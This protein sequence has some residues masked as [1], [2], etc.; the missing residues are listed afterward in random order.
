MNFKKNFK[1]KREFLAIVI[2]FILATFAFAGDPAISNVVMV[3]SAPDFGDTVKVDFDVCIAAYSNNAKVA[4]AISSF[5]NFVTA[6]MTGQTFVVYT[7]VVG[8]PSTT[9]LQVGNDFGATLPV[10]PQWADPK[11]CSSCG[12]GAADGWSRHMSYTFKIPDAGWFPGCGITKLYLQIGTDANTLNSDGWVNAVAGCGK[13]SLAWTIGIP[14]KS[15]SIHKRVEGV[16]ADDGDLAVYFIDY[17]YANGQLIINDPLPAGN[18]LQIVSMGPSTIISGAAVGATF[19]TIKWTLP[20]KTG[21][22]GSTTGSVWFLVKLK[23]PPAT[24][25]QVITNTVTGSMTGLADKTSQASLT[26][27][28]ITMNVVKSTAAKTAK[29]GDTITYFIDYEVRGSKLKVFQPFDNMITGALYTGAN[30]PPQWKF[31]TDR[32]VSGIWT[33]MDPCGT[34][35]R[36]IKADPQTVQYYPAILVDTG[37]TTKDRFCTGEIVVDTKI[38]GAYSG[39]DSQIIIRHNGLSGALSN[40]V[41]LIMSVDASPGYIAFQTVTN[42]VWAPIGPPGALQAANT[43]GIVGDKWFSIRINV[44]Q[45]GNDYVYKARAWTKGDPEPGGPTGQNWMITWT[46]AGAATS[47][48]WRCD[49]TGTYTDWRPGLGEQGGDVSTYDSFDNFVVYTPFTSGNTIV[50]DTIPTEVTFTNASTA[51]SGTNGVVKYWNLGNVS[52]TSSSLTWWGVVNSCGSGIVSNIAAMDGD[53]PVIPVISNEVFVTLLCSTPTNTPTST[54]TATFTATATNTPTK[55]STYTFTASPTKTSTP[56]NT[57]T[58]TQSFT[59]TNTNTSTATPTSTSTS[60]NTATPTQSFTFTNTN[61]STA[62]PTFSSTFTFSSTSTSTATPT[63]SFTFTSSFTHTATPTSTATPTNSSTYTVTST[64]T[65]TFTSS[66]TPTITPTSPPFPYLLKIAI[67]NEAGE[68]VRFIGSSPTNNTINQIILSTGGQSNVTLM[69]TQ[70]PLSIYL[71]NVETPN[72]LGDG[73]TNFEWNSNNNANQTTGSGVYYIKFEEL[74]MYGH[75]NV[76]IKEITVMV[77]QEYVEVCI[78]N[79]AGEKIKTIRDYKDVTNTKISLKVGKDDNGQV[80]VVKGNNDINITYGTNLNEYVIWDGLNDQ[81]TAVGAGSY[82]V[83]VSVVS[84]QG[85]TV[86]AAKSIVVLSEKVTYMKDVSIIPNPYSRNILDLK[87][88]KFAWVA[89]TETG[90]M[91]VTVYN[92]AGEKVRTINAT[93]ESGSVLWDVKS[94]ENSRIAA[95]YYVAVFESKS[96]TGHLDRKTA[97]LAIIGSNK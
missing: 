56:T 72:N 19:G 9:P 40:S 20:D 44:T 3:P 14:P 16:L 93:L 63:Q 28:S 32:G 61:T 27:G 57:A 43:P 2:L 88:I 83:Q 54:S 51:V 49:G 70:N 95:G 7:N 48:L 81:G 92:M 31:I 18:V 68:L 64:F 10:G 71:P 66:A 82:E 59:S 5:P 8:V 53:D 78:F 11:T 84:T 13:S 37:D 77:V 87:P 21:Q 41:G 34:G 74:D 69:T 26:V 89:G 42:G 29:I 79:S 1:G 62:T 52:D 33:I 39:A 45:V 25:G 96:T 38:E 6:N 36:Y 80:Y 15:F 85:R 65:V 47:P 46:Q 23:K 90:W 97:K 76:L 60:T 4:I 17:T 94:G 35:D 75:T 55:T 12:S 22:P 73:G 86:V 30:P 91:S 24:T 58:P 67:Y 50:Y